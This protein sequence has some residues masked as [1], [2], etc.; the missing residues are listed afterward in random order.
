MLTS[1][2]KKPLTIPPKELLDPPGGLNP[3]VLLFF[4]VVIM[5][6]LSSCGYWV[7]EWPHWLCFGINTLSL[8]FSGTIIHDAC[9]QSAHRNRI[10]NAILGHASALVLAFAFPVFTRVHLQH[11]GNVNH[12]K[13][14]PDH[15]VS[16]GGPLWLIAV[17]FLYHEVFF[18]QRQLWRKYELL[19]WFLSRLLIFTIVYISIQYH[20]L[21]YI[22]NFWF[23]P[24][25]V[26]GITLGFFF[27]YLPHRP[28]VER[29]RWKNARVYPGKILNML[30]LGQNYH[31]IH[32]LWPSI[33]WYN[34]QPAYY[35]MKPLLD[36]K[37]SP[38]TSG[39]LQKKDFL[40]FLY[41]IFIGLHF[42]H[43][44]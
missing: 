36:E 41:D 25:F 39:L 3:T 15:Y 19:E 21:G 13:D 35:L 18:F 40:E 43:H 17:R 37:G 44:E 12:P 26:V 20:F 34:Y 31:L 27:D 10:A 6:V 24:A 22:L 23:V 4:A 29:D 42:H 11:H 8:H 2:A 16:T 33:T 30:I 9:H 38:Q 7:W 32:H 28:F 14:D 5:L 1:E